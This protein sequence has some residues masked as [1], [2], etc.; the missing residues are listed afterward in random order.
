MSQINKAEQ[1]TPLIKTIN[2]FM[3]LIKGFMVVIFIGYLFSGV[4]LIKP[5]EVGIIL[6]MGKIVGQ[7]R[8]DQIKEAGWVFALPRPFDTVIRF[9]AKRILQMEINELACN[10]RIK[11]DDT[12]NISTIDPT[13]EG[14]CITGDDNVF[15]TSIVIK[16]QVKDP[17]R[18]IFDY[19]YQNGASEELIYNLVVAEMTSVSCRFSI[20]GILTKDKKELSEQVKKQVQEKLD[21]IDSGLE[22]VSLE[23]SEMIPPPFLA[24]DFEDVQSAY[25]DK[26]QFINKSKTLS[27]TKIQEA[28]SKYEKIVNE[29]E[30]YKEKIIA[31]AEAET[32]VFNN[33]Y[34]AWQR[35]PEEVSQEMK[36]NTL[37]SVNSKSGNIILFPDT[38]GFEGNTSLLLG[39]NGSI[40]VNPTNV[41]GYYESED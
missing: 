34:N 22:L 26:Y 15:Q 41:D 32:S 29:A 33:I 28:Q 39:L 10:K 16:Y 17:I 35:N 31:K 2:D 9:P 19:A 8:V 13:K 27:E 1:Q 21:K 24:F 25:V 11:K 4:T 40:Q 5:D 23:I 36:V 18:I 20:D 30:A 37:K 14:Y 12:G 7:P 38:K 6:R 3:S